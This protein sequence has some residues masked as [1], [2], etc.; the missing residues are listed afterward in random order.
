[1]SDQGGSKTFCFQ[2]LKE[3]D[4]DDIWFQKDG[5]TQPTISIVWSKRNEKNTHRF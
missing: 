1:M 3:N 2:E 4:M 5:V